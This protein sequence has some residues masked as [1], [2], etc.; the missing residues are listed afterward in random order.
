MFIDSMPFIRP[1]RWSDV[2]KNW[3]VLSALANEEL[4]DELAEEL[5]DDADE[6]D[7]RIPLIQLS[8]G[9]RFCCIELTKQSSDCVLKVLVGVD[10]IELSCSNALLSAAFFF[11][12]SIISRPFVKNS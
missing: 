8:V 6:R 4:K 2:L 7:E 11:S 3:Y 12:S 9:F 5:V 10:H 1:L